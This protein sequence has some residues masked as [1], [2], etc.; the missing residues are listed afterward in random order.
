MGLHSLPR[1]R[2]RSGGRP[3]SI[4]PALAVTLHYYK[5]R[6][7]AGGGVPATQ[8]EGRFLLV[9]LRGRY[10]GRSNAANA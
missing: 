9:F 5:C 7:G 8:Q 4:V 6:E 10:L 1:D 2:D 3:V